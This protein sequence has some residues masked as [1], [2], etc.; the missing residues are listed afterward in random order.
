MSQWTQNKDS[1]YHCIHFKKWKISKTGY[2]TNVREPILPNYLSGERIVEYISFP[3]LLA[4]YK[5]LTLSSRIQIWATTSTF[6]D[7]KRYIT[8]ANNYTTGGAQDVIKVIHSYCRSWLF[9]YTVS[10]FFIY[11]VENVLFFTLKEALYGFSMEV[12]EFL[13]FLLLRLGNFSVKLLE[14]FISGV[15]IR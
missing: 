15:N 14:L 11:Q 7:D 5:M 6:N 9:Q 3:S 2:L 13:E 1:V 10:F 4:L 12:P 8:C